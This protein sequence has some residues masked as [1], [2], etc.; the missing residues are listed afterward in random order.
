MN[1]FVKYNPGKLPQFV[2]NLPME[3]MIANISLKT[4][5]FQLFG[6]LNQFLH[7]FFWN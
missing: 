6:K 5:Y 2:N 4:K 7:G 3:G 1:L